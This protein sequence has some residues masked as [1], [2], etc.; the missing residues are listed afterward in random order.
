[1]K[2]CVFAVKDTAVM[3]FQVPQFI[4]HFGGAVRWFG[5][6]CNDKA[7][8]FGQH[9]EDYEIHDLGVFETDTG[10]WDLGGV[11]TVIRGKDLLRTA[12]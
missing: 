11:K 10:D 3:G 6:Q 9:P 2:L 12:S 5:D 7:T 8:A 4:A 1:M